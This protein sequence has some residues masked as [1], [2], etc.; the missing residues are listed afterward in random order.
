MYVVGL[1]GGIGSGKSTVAGMLG[2]HGAVV[3][4]VDG[5]GREVLEPG[6]RA[7]DPVIERFGAK[8]VGPDGHI[9]RA[10]LGAIVFSDP[11]ELAALEAISHPAI[12]AE[13]DARLGAMEPETIVV[14]DM[15][16]LTESKLG[17]LDSGRG[18]ELVVVVET[19]DEIR[20]PRLIDRGMTETDARARIAAQAS[21]EQRRAIAD[22][23][24]TNGSD[25]AALEARVGVLWATIERNADRKSSLAIASDGARRYL[26]GIGGRSV[27]PSAEALANLEELDGPLPESPSPTDDTIA[28]LVETVGPATMA[29][30]GGRYFGFVNG[31]THPAALAAS[32]LISAWDQNVA[33]GVMSPPAARLEEVA[34]RWMVDLLGLPDGTGGGFVS[35]ATMANLSGLATG[36]D[37]V[38]RRAGWDASSDGLLGAPPVTVYVGAEAHATVRKALGLAGLGR[39][40]VEVLSADDQGRIETGALPTISGPA[41]VCLQAGNVNSGAFDPFDELIDWA[42]EADAWVH[43]DGAF[44]LWAAASPARAHHTSGLERADSWA[45]DGHKWLNLTYDSGV[46]LVRDPAALQATMDVSAAYLPA[47]ATRDPMRF[48]PQSSQRARGVEAWAVLHALGR[49]GV[50]DLVDRCCRHATRLASGLA[51][52]G[53]EVVNDVVLNQVVV[54]FGD[55]EQ[56]RAVIDAVQRDG[57]CWCG[58][59]D[60]RGGA[61]MRISVSSWATTDDDIERSLEAILRCAGEGR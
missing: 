31:A 34:L 61:A 57:T 2:A 14:L 24:I 3:I 19:P 46:I 28:A 12:N 7:F 45:T 59:T 43:V 25:L 51:A 36:R 40:R 8:V 52:A 47:G 11:A 23:I 29:T 44:G 41:L 4:D 22:L 50:A 58:G 20:I 18:Y 17:Q 53:H 26:G 5:V 37:V 35:G 33:L 38:L 16:V 56:T 49:S 32:W 39:N 42:S 10:A 27:I 48:T 30:A 9:D 60:W 55:D 15:A 1:T 54:R 21:T 6:N 13:L